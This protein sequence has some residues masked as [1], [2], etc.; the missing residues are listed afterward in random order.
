MVAG[1]LVQFLDNPGPNLPVPKC[2]ISPTGL[3]VTFHVQT[4]AF[5]HGLGR[6]GSKKE[7]NRVTSAGLDRSL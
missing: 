4:T 3:L 6:V 2:S 5:G 1:L 7:S